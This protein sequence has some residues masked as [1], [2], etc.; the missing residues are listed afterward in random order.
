[1]NENP[2]YQKQFQNSME[3]YQKMV[4]DYEEL[5]NSSRYFEILSTMPFEFLNASH[6]CE[7]L[8]LYEKLE[9]KPRMYFNSLDEAKVL[10]K[11]L[12]GFPAK[13]EKLLEDASFVVEIG[14]RAEEIN[15]YVE[16]NPYLS[17]ELAISPNN[18][19]V[20]IAKRCLS[21]IPSYPKMLTK[22]FR[23]NY[24]ESVIYSLDK[25]SLDWLA[26]SKVIKAEDIDHISLIG[27]SDAYH[28]KVQ[29]LCDI[30][31]H[32]QPVV[33]SYQLKLKGVT[34]PNEDGSS[35]QKNLEELRKHSLES[36]EVVQLAAE[37]YEYQ[38]EIG[39]PEPAIR[40]SWNGKCIGNIA[41]SVAEEISEK[42]NNP[43]CTATLDHFSGGSDGMNLG[44]VINLNIIAPGYSQV[45]QEAS[46][47]GEVSAEEGR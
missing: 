37:S 3:T 22:K 19:V 1:M 39:S 38:P 47:E 5:T 11:N 7:Q 41:K 31:N 36:S 25:G 40:I 10:Y 34:F 28:E 21:E 27:E 16:N 15:R 8:A 9:Q 4:E 46:K 14:S 24:I 35:R 45:H 23:W 29:F 33:A 44:C 13:S 30:L 2:T 6:L 43:Q 26:K 18:E 32:P 17:K 12:I 42:F 20:D